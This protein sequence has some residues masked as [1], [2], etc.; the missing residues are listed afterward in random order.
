MSDAED[1]SMRIEIFDGADGRKGGFMGIEIEY[2][3][4][5]VRHAVRRPT[6]ITL[7]ELEQL[8]AECK[9]AV[10]RRIKEIE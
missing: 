9:A 3:P 10:M 6:M 5:R 4:K 2:V 7:L 1:W 8:I